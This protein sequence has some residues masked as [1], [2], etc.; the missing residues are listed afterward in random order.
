VPTLLRLIVA[1]IASLALLAPVAGCGD[2]SNEGSNEGSTSE[3]SGPKPPRSAEVPPPRLASRDREAFAAIQTAS[4]VLRA[5]VVAAAY[6]SANRIPAHP[7]RGAARKLRSVHPRN[8]L[9]KQLRARTA[10]ALIAAASPSADSKAVAAAAIAEADRIDAG[11]R[12]YA[13]SHPAANEVAP[14]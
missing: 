5:A 9:L 7:L 14:G 2:G 11:L 3:T 8:P 10:N 6:G 13:A 4:G 12:E 1:G